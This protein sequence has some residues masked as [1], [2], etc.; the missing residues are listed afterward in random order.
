MDPGL[1]FQSVIQ[2]NESKREKK[3]RWDFH[4]NHHESK[5]ISVVVVV[6]VEK[7]K[8]FWGLLLGRGFIA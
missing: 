2:Q 6:A 8:G 5:L 4:E 3:L 1:G 7:E